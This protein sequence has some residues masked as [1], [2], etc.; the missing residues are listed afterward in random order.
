MKQFVP[1]VSQADVERI[2]LRD[3]PAEQHDEL[4]AAIHALQ[5]REK[6]RIVLACMK[7]AGGDVDRLKGSLSDAEGYYRES[8]GDAEYPNYTKKWFRIENL[9]EEEKDRIIEKD[10][11]QYLSWLNET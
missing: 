6:D 3:Y 7:N 1:D 8:I 11:D 4:R 5:H 2:L 10:R 9:S